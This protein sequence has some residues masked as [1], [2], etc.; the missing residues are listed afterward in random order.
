MR[1]V[2]G[3]ERGKQQAVGQR[4]RE[5]EAGF[6]GADVTRS[7]EIIVCGVGERAPSRGAGA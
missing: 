4:F 5:G 6:S 1:F 3:H 2:L 7:L